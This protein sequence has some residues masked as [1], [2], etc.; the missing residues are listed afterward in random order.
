MLQMRYWCGDGLDVG[1]R[2]G[3]NNI[4]VRYVE[5]LVQSNM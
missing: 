1:K 5:Y 2:I 3:G 4:L